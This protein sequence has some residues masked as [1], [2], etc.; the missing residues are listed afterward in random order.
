MSR[1]IEMRENKILQ[2]L[3]VGILYSLGL[4]SKFLL[5]FKKKLTGNKTRVKL[6]MVSLTPVEKWHPILYIVYLHVETISETEKLENAKEN[7][8]ACE[9]VV[10]YP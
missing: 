4:Y 5:L 2:M 8:N 7:K 10:S 9:F 1:V 6:K 3:V